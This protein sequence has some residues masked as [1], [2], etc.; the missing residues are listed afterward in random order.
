MSEQVYFDFSAAQPLAGSVH[1]GGEYARSVLKSLLESGNA[2][3]LVLLVDRT[4]PAP[5]YFDALVE[6]HGL[7]LA[8]FDSTDSLQAVLDSGKANR[9]YSALPYEHGSLDLSRLDVVFTI[10]G[11]RPIELPTDRYEIIYGSGVPG[12]LK[13]LIKRVFEGPYKKM[14]LQ[15]FQSLLSANARSTTI[16]VPS[17]HTRNA[18]FD[19]LDVP[20]NAT[21]KTFYSPQ[22]TVIDDVSE[23]GGSIDEL[24]LSDRG[25]FLIVSG[26][27]WIKNSYRALAAVR[28]LSSTFE[29]F[30]RFD[31]VVTGGLPKR[32]ARLGTTKLKV[33]PYVDHRLLRALYAHAFAL[34]YP[35]LNEGFG[36]PPV[37]AMACGT[38]VL[39]S[40]ACSLPEIA[41]DA[42]L[43]FS[44][45]EPAEM[46]EQ[47]R[48]LVESPELWKTHQARGLRRYAEV[49]KRQREDL[50]Q[51]CEL[52]MG[53]QDMSSADQGR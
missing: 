35:T 52:I 18:V 21:I 23:D 32:A 38:P 49:S 16:V 12:V 4:R 30:R 31:I 15:K 8:W 3:R 17:D 47:M 20:D 48:R 51:L 7:Q 50:E 53:D 43:Y 27:R 24:G 2:E 45:Y 29:P 1:G 40:T 28:A 44:P 26:G 33:L 11:L 22:T 25:Y 46:A 5:D 39:S 34:L 9:F 37:E 14:Q 36:Y 6:Q 41:G 19:Y 42:P 10:H 13:P